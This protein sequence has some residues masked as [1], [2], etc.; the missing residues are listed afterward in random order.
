MHLPMKRPPTLAGLALAVG[1]L[2]SAAA[3][4]P[5]DDPAPLP[6][7][8]TADTR[9]GCKV[10]NPQP[11]PGET[12]TWSGACKDGLASGPGAVEWIEN[13]LVTE[14][15]DGVRVAGHLQGPGSLVSSNGDRF[16]GEWKDDR[17]NG[18]GTYTTADGARYVGEWKDDRFD[19]QG[20]LTDAR[21]NKYVGAWKAGRRN[22]Q[23]TATFSN[24]S[25][26]SGPWIDD[27]PA[28]GP[29]VV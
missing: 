10:W 27:Q 12:M 17:K 29:G 7:G 18:H 24:G 16:E 14:H 13:G 20:T 1:L 22:G 15:T 9:T 3:A 19:G 26:Y 25:T 28:T 2:A 6:S 21:G 5:A 23:G 11:Q 8:W 4:Q